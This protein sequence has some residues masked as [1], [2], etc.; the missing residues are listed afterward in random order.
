MIISR[1]LVVK[2]VLTADVKCQVLQ[3]YGTKVLMK[4]PRGLIGKPYLSKCNMREVVMQN[5]E[6]YSTKQA[7]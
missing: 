2:L 5:S 1:D 6:P 3:W 4:E 7:T